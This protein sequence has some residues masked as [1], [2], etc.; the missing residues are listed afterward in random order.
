MKKGLLDSLQEKYGKSETGEDVKKEPLPDPTPVFIP[1]V[2]YDTYM[3]S[4]HWRKF[5]NRLLHKR[6]YKCERCGSKKNLHLH[7]IT[8][9][10]FGMEREEDLEI[11]CKTCH[12]M[13]HKK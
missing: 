6:G 2:D 13:A 5:R 10:R 3:K 7:H 8:Y 1:R 4:D 12:D 11:L 9:E